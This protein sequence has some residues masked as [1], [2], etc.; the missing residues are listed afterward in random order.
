MQS[1]LVLSTFIDLFVLVFNTLL[2]LRVLLGYM[3]QESNNFFQ[4][5]ISLTEPLLMPVR[6][7]LPNSPGVDFAP[8][9]TF[10]LLQGLQYLAHNLL[11]T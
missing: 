5:L 7:L 6:K 8:L 2:I 9:V 10:F 3:V 11:N 1:T 4:T